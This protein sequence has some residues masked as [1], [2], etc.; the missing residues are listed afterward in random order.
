MS[1][2]ILHSDCNCFYASV[3]LLHHPELRG[4]PVAVGGDPEARH[5]IVLTAD[6]TA[7]RYGVKT[8]MALWQA[9]QVC[10]D[11]TFLPPRMD[12]YLRFSRMAQEIYA[13][14]TDKREPYGI[15]ESWLDVT[16]S[17]TLKGDGFHIAQEIS[18]RMKK[19]LGITVSVGV[20]FN[21][22]FAKL[23]SD[24]KK[25]DAITTMYEDEFQRKAWCLPVSDLLYVGNATNKKLYS[26]G[27]RT[28]G[29]L[30]KSDETLLVRKLGKMGSILWAF[31][32]G[33]D[34]SPVKLE[35]TSAPVKSV[36]NSTTTPRDMETDEDVK[37]VLYILAE[38]VAA[39]LR[40][41]G[42]R[43]RTVEISVRDKELFHM[44]L[45]RELLNNC[46]AHSE[47]TLGGRIYLNEFEDKIILTNPGSFLPGKIE[48]VLDPG[49][50]PPFYRNQ[51][52]AET[53]VK[54]NMIDSQSIGIRRVFRIQR[55]RYFPLPD[56]DL[57]N[58]Q[59]VKVCVYGKVLDENYS[60]ILFANPDFD[61]ETVFLIDCVQKRIKIDKEAVKH[62]RKLKVIEGMSPNIFLSASVSETIGEQSQ[63]VKNK[64]FNDQYYRDLIVKYLEQYGSAKKRDVRELLWDKLPEVMDDKQ[65]ESKVKNL[66]AKMRR[67]GIITTDSENQQKS[68]WILVKDLNK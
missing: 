27:I 7:K 62:L 4:K 41:N 11:I 14:Y 67:M 48:K 56:Y 35:N 32:N 33:Y 30:A 31:A 36:G 2:T 64:A 47:Y 17:A 24:Y 63:Y 19:E 46:I 12:L 50:N 16:D 66:L 13:D 23:G 22:I 54:L 39:R 1:R 10:P 59:Q 42:F 34:E 18:S 5:G 49:Y 6:Y 37:I 51:L 45:L 38:S 55:D 53:M 44:W 40:E 29:D 26:M 21:K 15:D 60:Q 68:S 52:L 20:S 9:K 43:C 58:R 3:E 25:P 61:L 65:K 57:S 8:G 28:I